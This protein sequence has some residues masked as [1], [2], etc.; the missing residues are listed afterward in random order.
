M[1]ELVRI[2]G[3]FTARCGWQAEPRRSRN[4]PEREAAVLAAARPRDHPCLHPEAAGHR[5]RRLAGASGSRWPCSS[6]P[7]AALRWWAFGLQFAI[8][9]VALTFSYDVALPLGAAGCLAG[10]PA[11]AVQR[12]HAARRGRQ[13]PPRPGRQRPLP[14]GHRG[15]LP[16]L[17]AR[18]SR[19]GRGRAGSQGR[20]HR[21]VDVV[22]R[23][24]HGPARRTPAGG[25]H[26]RPTRRSGPTSSCPSSE[27]SCSRSRSPCS[28]RTP[29]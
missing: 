5:L 15:L 22:P 6:S 18:S 9:S 23:G 21:R 17:R 27:C 29:A 12:A 26:L 3:L 7:G 16:P 24:A 11:R 13:A 20:P 1:G 25:A 8:M 19:S 2:P 28:G 14:H 10:D 4:V